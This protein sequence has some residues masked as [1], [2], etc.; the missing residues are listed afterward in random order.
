MT[1][2]PDIF[3]LLLIA[4]VLVILFT[5]AWGGIS[6]APWVPLWKRDIRRMLRLA[7][8]KPNELV[9]DLGAGDG[10]ILLCAAGEFQARA[11]GLELAVLP[12]TLGCIKLRLAGLAGKAKLRYAN[13]FSHS[14]G[15]AD[16]I[17]VFLTPQAMQKLKP[18]FEAECKPGCRIVSFA[19]HVPGWQ[20]TNIDKPNQKTT[21]IYLYQ[22]P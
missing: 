3:G 22:R 7:N 6:A 14:V 13:F 4:V 18:K 9:Y 21:A 16:V 2:L 15:D 17:C 1:W 10:R 8:V 19:F 20:P 12:Y 5:F 11:V